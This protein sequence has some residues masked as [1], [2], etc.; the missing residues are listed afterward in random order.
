[1][2]LCV[3]ATSEPTLMKLSFKKGVPRNTLWMILGQGFRFVIQAAYFTV[4]A[5]SLGAYNYGAFVGVVAL[6]GIV[7]P[8]GGLGAGNLL[9]KN[10]AREHSLFAV[11]LGRGLLTTLASS[12]VLFFGVMFLSRF[13]LPSVIPRELVLLVS[14]SDLV[15]LNLITLCG[16][17]F[18]AFERLSWTATI[19]VMISA[20][21]LSGA[22][23]LVSVHRHPT[24]LEWGFLYLY[25]TAAVTVGALALVFF[26]LGWPRF[27][28][29][30]SIE[31]LREGF[32]FSTSQSAQTIYND[33]DK[34]MLAR[35]GTLDATGI[36]GAAYRLMDVSFV[37]ISSLLAAAYP[38]FFRKGANGIRATI[39]YA[40]RL[41]LHALAYSSVVSI[42]IL[43]FA[44]LVP[45]VL[46]PEYVRTV[47]ALRW[48]ALLPILKSVHY[49]LSDA[50]TGAGYQGIRTAIQAGVALLNVLLNLWLIPAY[51]WRGAAW[52]S[53]ASD[54]TLA[55]AVAAALFLL[56]RNARAVNVGEVST[57][58]LPYGV[59]TLSEP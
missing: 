29:R 42:C 38:T 5:R 20:S 1:M 53:L 17:A 34:T 19:N 37:P 58:H 55:S 51:S 4:I 39:G 15:G 16:H 11:Y 14:V 30:R 13:L 8:F 54:A 28:W 3:K 10:V 25:T 50:L 18:V 46:G 21:R 45:Y 49:F 2:R 57:C 27:S 44:G 47:D 40:K 52:S 7:F 31:E 56:S 33:I 35:L 22:L 43:L 9:I 48:L 23:I 59:E 6:V 36:Y 26:K 41:L 12:G 32:Y 24:A